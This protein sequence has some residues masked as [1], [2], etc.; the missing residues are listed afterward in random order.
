MHRKAAKQN[1]CPIPL[2]ARDFF[3]EEY[4]DHIICQ[5][6]VGRIMKGEN[7]GF[8]PAE[9][10]DISL[11]AGQIFNMLSGDKTDYKDNFDEVYGKYFSKEFMAEV[12]KF[13]EK[14]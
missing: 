3:P 6:A 10:L 11:P 2:R 12:T 7:N 8:L 13:V 14:T 9:A 5:I 4:T 1:I